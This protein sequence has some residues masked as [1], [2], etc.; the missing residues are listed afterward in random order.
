MKVIRK[1]LLSIYF[2]LDKN[3]LKIV[4]A[5]LVMGKNGEITVNPGIK[6]SVMGSSGLVETMSDNFFF[7]SSGNTGCI[8]TLSTNITYLMDDERKIDYDI[9]FSREVLSPSV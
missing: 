4:P 9:L 6:S 8:G 2:D 7:T 1:P 5:M 3:T